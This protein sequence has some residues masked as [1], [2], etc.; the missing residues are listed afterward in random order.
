MPR[1]ITGT[2]A[3]LLLGCA[4]A[5]SGAP[6]A[7][8][9]A[10]YQGS[11]NYTLMVPTGAH[12]LG[13]HGDGFVPRFSLR[14]KALRGPVAEAELRSD[15]RQGPRAAPRTVRVALGEASSGVSPAD[16]AR[17]GASLLLRIASLRLP[18]ASGA[19]PFPDARRATA[20]GGEPWW[21]QQIR[22]GR[23]V[24]LDLDLLTAGESAEAAAC[25]SVPVEVEGGTT[26]ASDRCSIAA[27][28]SAQ[29]GWPVLARITRTVKAT[30]HAEARETITFYRLP[31]ERRRR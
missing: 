17:D 6:R 20:T 18:E 28:V 2:L 31:A 27:I 19:T 24:A 22:S 7:G 8:T 13:E 16:S 26:T 12:F 15:E 5:V 10:T 1:F 11:T 23:D 3:L 14:L 29:D 25:R 30:N 4:S 21:S 9:W